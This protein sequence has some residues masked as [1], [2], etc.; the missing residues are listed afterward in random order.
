[1]STAP[2]IASTPRAEQQGFSLLEV[3][4]TLTI[5]AIALLG[6]AGLQLRALQTGQSSQA[7]SQA[8]LLAADLAERIEANR[9]EA[10]KGGYQFTKGDTLATGTDCSTAYCSSLDL[11]KYDINQWNAQIPLLL[12]QAT[13]WSVAGSAS[14]PITYTIIINWMDRSPNATVG[15]DVTSSGEPMSYK[16]TRTVYYLP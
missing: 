6:A 16:S 9:S 4:V 13:S 8:V 12:P 1:M 3:L 15:G 2:A 11:R 14:N 7:R 10:I 5:T